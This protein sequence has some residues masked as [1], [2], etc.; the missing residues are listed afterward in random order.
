[1]VEDREVLAKAIPDYCI[2]W[3]MTLS[4]ILVLKL[5]H[6]ARRAVQAELETTLEYGIES[7]SFTSDM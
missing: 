2:P 1:M 6:N 4:Q 3:R 7:M 5:F